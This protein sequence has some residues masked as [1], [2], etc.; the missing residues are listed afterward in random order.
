MAW[1]ETIIAAHTAVTQAVSHGQRL[2]SSRYFVW[3][4]DGSNDLEAND[5]HAEGAV[6]GTTDLFSKTEFDPW[7]AAMEERVSPARTVWVRAG[8]RTTSVCPTARAPPA[9]TSLSAARRRASTP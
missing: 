2:K 4:E 8:K 6:Q 5:G 7:A 9:G 1:Y 3:Q